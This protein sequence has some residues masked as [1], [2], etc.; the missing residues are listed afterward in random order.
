MSPVNTTPETPIAGPETQK[1]RTQMGQISR[2][3]AVFFAGTMFT[4]AAGYLFKVYLARVLGAEALGVY[5]L[6]MTII[7]FVGVFNGLGLPQSAVRFVAL[8]AATGR[9]S[10]LRGFIVRAVAMLLAANVVLGFFVVLAGPWVAQHFYHTPA[11]QGY[12]GLFALIMI[13]GALTTFFGQVLQGYKDVSRRTVITNFIGTP[14]MMLLTIGLVMLGTGLRGY[15]LAQVVSAAVVLLLLVAVAWRLS[16]AAVRTAAGSLP[17]LESQVLFF[18]AA[19]F[20]IGLMDFLLAQIDKILIGFYINA[21]EVGIYSVAMAI[22]AFVPVALQSVNQI[23]SPTIADLHARAEQELLGRLFQTL[24]KWILAF[25]LPLATVVIVFSKPLMRI[26]GL[27]FEA[28]WIV[29]VVGTLGQLVNCGTGSVGYLLLMSGNQ[30]RLI[31]VQAT[32]TGVMVALNVLLIPPLGILG[33][34]LATALTAVVSNIWYLREVRDALGISP[35]NRRYWQLLPA[36]LASVAVVVS[37][38]FAARSIQPQWPVIVMS[39]AA[40]YLA[41][42]GTAAIVGL[43]EDDQTIAKAVWFRVRNIFGKAA[44]NAG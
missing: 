39:A 15:I 12:L 34:A 5:A 7:G 2:H 19:V 4:A 22:V 44:V 30:K 32:M 37:F 25:T 13:L 6:G 3:S 36:V 28:G 8:Y 31:K 18:G 21:R 40:S 10:E 33:A 20:G 11:L 9:Y 29:L 27:D 35:Y 24:T 38:R 23:F 14:V 17:R 43:D 1:F 42:V 16:P 26:F 41:L